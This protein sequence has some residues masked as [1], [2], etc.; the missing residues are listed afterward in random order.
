VPYV[1]GLLLAFAVLAVALFWG[2][3]FGRL[4]GRRAWDAGLPTTPCAPAAAEQMALARAAGENNT[5]LDF[6][7]APDSVFPPAEES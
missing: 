6:G 2:D 1:A 7:L 5:R 4:S 3:T